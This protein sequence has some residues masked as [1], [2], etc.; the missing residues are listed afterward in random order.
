MEIIRGLCS[1]EGRLTGTDAERRAANWLAERLR[2]QGR[3]AEV[4]PTSVH[5]QVG[6]V[7]AAHAALGF[8]G[9]LVAI[10]EPTAGFAIVLATAVSLYF[11]FNARFYLLRRLFFRRASQNVFSPAG[12]G[13]AAARLILV[14]HYDAARTG[15]VYNE[16][17]RRREARIPPG[18]RGILAPPR[19][20]FWSLA[21]L[22]PILGARAAG[23]DE[24]WLNLIQ[25]LPTLVLLVATFLLVDIE[26]SDVVPGANDN[27]SGVAVAL[28]AAKALDADP[29]RQ[30]EVCVLL[31]GGNECLMEG[32]RSFVRRY[33]K[34]SDRDSTHFLALEMLGRGAA[35][36]YLTAEGLAVTYR[37]S[38]RL[39]QL[40]EA[41]ATASAEEGRDLD[42]TP[43]ALPT[44]TDAL[45]A[46]LAGYQALTLRRLAKNG[47][48]GL[49]HH[50]A[51]DTPDGIEPDA[52]AQSER[53]VVELVRQLDRD[54]SRR[55]GE[56]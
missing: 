39:A 15:Y 14:A 19:L 35:L 41:I 11:D 18:A 40:C 45:P 24:S 31:T 27:A 4:E 53:F 13:D 44:A 43:V 56:R 36:H 37:H 22:L 48:P 2:A 12:R 21:F 10:A 8:G 6:L 49:E 16:R 38:V 20:L 25:L 33:R 23:L 30:L 17:T 51:A 55:A 34:R 7:V 29:P 32:M 42:A 52:L 5:P 47:L 28:S 3:R 46:T 9:S 1:F 50:T 26:L 54:V